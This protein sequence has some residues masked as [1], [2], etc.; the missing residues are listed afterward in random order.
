M[1]QRLADV[2]QSGMRLVHIN[3]TGVKPAKQDRPGPHLGAYGNPKK[4]K[5]TSKPTSPRA[6][7]EPDRQ[8]G[9]RRNGSS[10][11]QADSWC[12]RLAKPVRQLGKTSAMVKAINRVGCRR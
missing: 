8:A 6:G 12:A 2:E 11:S 1:A 10:G 7:H 5:P 4:G 9:K 3:Q